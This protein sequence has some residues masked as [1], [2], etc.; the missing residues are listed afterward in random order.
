MR[1]AGWAR[2]FRLREPHVRGQAKYVYVLDRRGFDIA[3]DVPGPRGAYIR[4]DASFVERR[5]E[6]VLKPLTTCTPTPCC[7]P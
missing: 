4:G 3:R 7:S 6:S 1:K 5:F 2:R